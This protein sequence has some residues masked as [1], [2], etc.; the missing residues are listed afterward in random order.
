ME[1]ILKIV[2]K[3]IQYDTRNGISFPVGIIARHIIDLVQKKAI[4][5]KRSYK[6]ISLLSILYL[7]MLHLLKG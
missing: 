2:G 3:E 7:F 6:D 4:Y 5:S 1:F